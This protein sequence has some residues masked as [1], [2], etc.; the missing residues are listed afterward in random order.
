MTESLLIT[1]DSD[2]TMYDGCMSRAASAVED[3]PGC[4]QV[5]TGVWTVEQASLFNLA[6]ELKDWLETL[7]DDPAAGRSDPEAC[8]LMTLVSQALSMVDWQE[9][10]EHY[11][12]KLAEQTAS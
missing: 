1:M 7:L 5:I 4:D 11:L 9:V 10:A 6:D 2:R 3:A 12:A 8:L